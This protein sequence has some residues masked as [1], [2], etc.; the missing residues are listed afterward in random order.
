MHTYSA[1]AMP[2]S[3]AVYKQYAHPV[4]RDQVESREEIRASYLDRSRQGTGDHQATAAWRYNPV[5]GD[6]GLMKNTHGI[7]YMQQY[8]M[9]E[10]SGAFHP[11]GHGSGRLDMKF[12]D[13]SGIQA[14]SIRPCD[15]GWITAIITNNGNVCARITK[16]GVISVWKV[17]EQSVGKMPCM[18]NG[19]NCGDGAAGRMARIAPL[20]SSEEDAA[21]GAGAR[22]LY[23]YEKEDK[24]RWLVE[25]DGSCNTISDKQEVTA[26]THWPLYQEWSTT[27][28]GNVMWVTAWNKDAKGQFGPQD[29]PNSVNA[30]GTKAEDTTDGY[31]WGLTPDATNEAKVTIYY[32][33]AQEPGKMEC[34]PPP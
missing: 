2:V 27:L 4:P 8:G 34:I 22:F 13:D 26:Y 21:C 15:D 6:I 18:S 32:S 9:S 23:G 14:N 25:V 29:S 20:G 16:D 17:I 30:Y 12:G 11:P 10:T 28:D 33:T 31:K 1:D 24:T 7:V 3:D 5:I 19:A